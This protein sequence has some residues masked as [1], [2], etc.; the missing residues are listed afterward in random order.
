MSG[1][2]EESGVSREDSHFIEPDFHFCPQGVDRTLI[3]LLFIHR[4]TR[5]EGHCWDAY[6]DD[7]F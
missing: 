4:V 6:V 1:S 3:S 7:F 2:K 5:M